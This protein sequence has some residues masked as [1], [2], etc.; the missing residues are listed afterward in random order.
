MHQAPVALDDAHGLRRPRALL[1]RVHEAVSRVLL[2]G[3]RLPA[4]RR[5]YY[6]ITGR[7]D[8]VLNTSPP[9][10]HGRGRERSSPTRPV[11][12][13][14]VVGFPHDVKGEES[15]PTSF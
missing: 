8:D 6:W 12:E 14:A 15:A 1:E 13:A 3:R 9:H 5:R 2:H 4:R 7:V 10:R 11:S